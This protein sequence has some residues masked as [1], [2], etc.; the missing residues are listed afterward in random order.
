MRSRFTV[1]AAQIYLQTI[2]V[3]YNNRVVRNRAQSTRDRRITQ[4]ILN[5]FVF[6]VLC[7]PPVNR[8]SGHS[9]HSIIGNITMPVSNCRLPRTFWIESGLN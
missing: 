9:G 3:L 5:T 1:C 6:I 4:V 7:L 8:P 2:I